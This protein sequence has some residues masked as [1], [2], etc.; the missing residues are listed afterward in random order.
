MADSPSLAAI[1]SQIAQKQAA[2]S[3]LVAEGDLLTARQAAVAADIAVLDAAIADLQATLAAAHPVPT[4]TALNITKLIVAS[5]A[6]TLTV[7]GTGFGSGYTGIYVNG[8]LL[9]TTVLSATSAS[10]TLG[11]G[12]LLA[13]GSLTVQVRNGAPG[14]GSSAT[15]TVPIVYPE[16]VLIS[17]TPSPQDPIQAGST[18]V[19]VQLVGSGFTVDTIVTLNGQVAAGVTFVSST[20]LTVDIPDALIG[21]ANYTV[22]I[23]VANG[24]PGGG[25]STPVVLSVV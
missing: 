14:G 8:T 4:L 13:V 19:F 10:C 23:Y 22:G 2:K 9:T 11:S 12:L 24:A 21:V 3:R 17:A 25:L 18:G 6:Q 16:P 15:L 7:T 5:G 20:Q 1:N